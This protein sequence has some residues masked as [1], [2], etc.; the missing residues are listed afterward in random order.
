MIRAPVELIARIRAESSRI[1]VSA[2]DKK[3]QSDTLRFHPVA[4]Y[5]YVLHIQYI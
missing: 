2:Y 5:Y 3:S 1:R 4:E